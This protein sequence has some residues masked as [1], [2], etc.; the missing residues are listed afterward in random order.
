LSCLKLRLPLLQSHFVLRLALAASLL[1]SG[2]SRLPESFAPPP[3]QASFEPAAT[4]LSYFVAMNDPRASDYLVQGFRDHSDGTWRWA[5]DHPVL[6]F[7]LPPVDSVNFT[8]VLVLPDQ[9][10]PLTGPQTLA[11]AVN[12]HPLDRAR[13]ETAGEHQYT[14]PVPAEFLK[15]GSVNLVALEPEKVATPH[16]GERLSFVLVRAG[17]TE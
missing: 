10:F 6:R 2:C 9:T 4:G 11:I 3:Q 17:F 16:L 14:H 12:G 15:P 13:F 1:F 8:M 5:Y 7:R